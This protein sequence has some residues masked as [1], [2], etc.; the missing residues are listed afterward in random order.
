MPEMIDEII[1]AIGVEPYFRDDAV[2]IYHADARALLPQMD[3]N[4]VNVVL[5]DPPYGVEGG[6][7]GGNTSFG[8]AKY[9][10][11]EWE[12]TEEYVGQL[13]HQLILPLCQ[14][15]DRVV[16][17]PGQRCLLLYPR[18]DDMG[19]FWHPASVTHGSWGFTTF[20]PILY[21][22]ADPRGGRGQSAS[23]LQVTERA[24]VDGHPCPKPLGA[25]KWLL[26]KASL[27]GETI[28][29]PFMG[30]GTT[31]RAAKDLGRYAIG[32]EIEKKYCEIA[33]KRMA[34]TVMPLSAG[35][36]K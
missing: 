18:A 14:T 17:T 11:G 7:G 19:C 22:G 10:P 28:L 12:D 13:V 9:A 20:T 16:I 23:G 15:I 26:N 5:T 4:S 27:E 2:V 1:D 35:R 32:I 3:L 33:A 6:R 29:D 8:K 25:W 36:A 34:Q 30:S 24:D 31:L 21:Y